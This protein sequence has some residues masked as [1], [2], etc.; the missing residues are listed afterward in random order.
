MQERKKNELTMKTIQEF[1]ENCHVYS[2]VDKSE[3]WLEQ[4]KSGIGGSEASVILNINPYKT[5]Y[6][7]YMDKKNKT[8]T[9]ITNEAIEKGN[10]LEQPLIDVFYA[11][12][13]Q[14]TPIDT[15]HIS[16]KSKK[17][18]FMNANLDG[19]FIDENGDKCL[20]EIKTT[21]I[22]SKKS[23]D[24][25]GVWNKE[26]NEWENRIPDNYYCQ[27]LHYM[28]VTG[29]KHAVLYAL[30]DFGYK[31]SQELRRYDVYMDDVEQDMKMI[32]EEEKKFWDRVEANDPPPFMK[33]N[34]K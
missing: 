22:M 8:I 15:K 31:E 30:L 17:Y 23:L 2:T 6:E 19:A 28:I 26:T 11:L 3:E 16:L 32:I 29:I 33:M 34:F 10:R 20:L 27:I 14:Y 24:E 13:P 5:P 12:Y 25:W 9:H 4:R 18:P 7:L 1:F 21:T